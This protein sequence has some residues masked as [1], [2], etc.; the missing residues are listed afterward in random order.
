MRIA[1]RKLVTV[2]SNVFCIEFS[3]GIRSQFEAKERALALE[4]TLT[5]RV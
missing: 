4:D 2:T 1:L 3:L 5:L